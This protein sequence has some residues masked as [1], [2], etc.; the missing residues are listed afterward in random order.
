ME[1]KVSTAGEA[2]RAAASA[3]IDKIEKSLGELAGAIPAGCLLTDPVCRTRFKVF[4]EEVARLREEIYALHPP[5][6]P[7]KLPDDKAIDHMVLAQRAWL[8]QWLDDVEKAG[9]ASAEALSPQGD[10]G[11]TWDDLRADAEKAY[12]H[13]CLSFACP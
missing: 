12:A 13:P 10:A 9:R 8:G 4:A 5:S 3:R 2:K 7:P 1:A 6:C 11:S